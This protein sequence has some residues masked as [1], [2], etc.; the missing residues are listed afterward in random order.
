MALGL[1]DNHDS[2]F[3]LILLTIYHLQCV[4]KAV[5]FI[6]FQ[7][8]MSN[9]PRAYSGW[10][11]MMP[12]SA[13]AVSTF[14]APR[15]GNPR[16]T[17]S[18]RSPRRARWETNSFSFASFRASSGPSVFAENLDVAS[19]FLFYSQDSAHFTPW[20]WIHWEVHL[21]LVDS[22]TGIHATRSPTRH[23][24]K[25][26]GLVWK[27]WENYMENHGKAS[28]THIIWPYFNH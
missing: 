9:F 23:I 10:C 26:M 6:N 8:E 2:G 5:I 4:H 27:W 7:H 14:K 25:N 3:H 16:S 20:P 1:P 15:R 22:A 24:Y 21:F 18:L 19:G 12:P 13:R 28:K 17:P 11:P